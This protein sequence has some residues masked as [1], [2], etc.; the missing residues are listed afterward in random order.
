MRGG[1]QCHENAYRRETSGATQPLERQ[2][3]QVNPLRASRLGA[4]AEIDGKLVVNCL[5]FTFSKKYLELRR[6]VITVADPDS[7]IASSM[8]EQVTLNH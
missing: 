6:E 8:V 2:E 3:L 4:K 7:R 5:S 1:Y